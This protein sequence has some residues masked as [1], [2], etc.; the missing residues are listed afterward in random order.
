MSE[1][2][3]FLKALNEQIEAETNEKIT[4]AMRLFMQVD[5]VMK[6]VV[7]HATG[8]DNLLTAENLR[9]HFDTLDLMD[10]LDDCIESMEDDLEFNK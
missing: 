9:Q 7:L 5:D 2:D 1:A 8:F 3:E 10:G 6:A 4:K